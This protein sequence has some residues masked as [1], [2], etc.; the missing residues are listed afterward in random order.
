MDRPRFQFTIMG[1]LMATFWIAVF[2]GVSA[3]AA[4]A[5][6][7]VGVFAFPIGYALI[8]SPFLAAGSLFGRAG[9]AALAGLVGLV[10]LAVILALV[11]AA[12][13]SA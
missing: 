1:I 10:V 3:A 4:R 12:V 6:Q 5:K 13:R 7:D 2:F 9:A 8:V 11:W